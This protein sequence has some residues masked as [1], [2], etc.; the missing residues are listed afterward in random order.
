[1]DLAGGREGGVEGKPQGPL[2][3]IEDLDHLG[4]FEAAKERREEKNKSRQ[5]SR[6]LLFFVT[7]GEKRE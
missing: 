3:R 1:M 5:K 7:N 6:L 4:R 2:S